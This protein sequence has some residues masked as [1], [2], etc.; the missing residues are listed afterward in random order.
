MSVR[1]NFY[2]VHLIFF[3]VLKDQISEFKELD[4]TGLSSQSSSPLRLLV[5]YVRPGL[6][7][8][9]RDKVSIFRQAIDFYRKMSACSF[10][11]TLH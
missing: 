8:Q 1:K 7:L 10:D 11:L 2:Q 3:T 6:K 4:R 5:E 9:L